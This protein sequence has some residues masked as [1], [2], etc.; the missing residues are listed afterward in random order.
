ME[1]PMRNLRT[2]TAIAAAA[3]LSL[4]A[5]PAALAHSSTSG[6]ANGSPNMNICVAQIDCTYINYHN[7]KPTDVIK[8]AGTIVDWSLN[9][10]SSG[11]QV[12]LRLLRPAPHG[13]FKLIHTTPLRTVGSI[14]V[15]TFPAHIKVKRGDV[16]A[17]RNDTSGLYMSTAPAGT[18]VRYFG[19]GNPLSDGSTGKPDKVAPQLRVLL[20][21]HVKY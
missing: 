20:S 13:A 9:A 8:H 17:L 6:N 2:L 15:N 14:G 18:C 12:Q 1:T 21:A 16:L 19:Y 5:A 3:S 11:G 10:A 7:N 4:A